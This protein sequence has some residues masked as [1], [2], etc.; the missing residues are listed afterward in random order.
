LRKGGFEVWAITSRD[1]E[2]VTAY[3]QNNGVDL[4]K[5]NIFF[6]EVLGAGKPYP[7]VYCHHL[8]QFRVRM[9]FGLLLFI[10][11]ILLRLRGIGML[12]RSF[13]GDVT[14]G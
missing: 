4:P 1:E 10:C 14:V 7:I 11:G 9:R 8:K 2:R 13:L 6:R 5:N 3:I 12:Y